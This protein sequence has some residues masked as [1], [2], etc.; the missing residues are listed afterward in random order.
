MRS[1]GW[2]GEQPIRRR[3]RNDCRTLAGKDGF[4]GKTGARHGDF[5]NSAYFFIILCLLRLAGILRSVR[6][7]TDGAWS[8]CRRFFGCE[9]VG[10]FAS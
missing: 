7:G 6:V 2:R 1:G 8:D 10:E 4:R 5:I 3:W 9:A